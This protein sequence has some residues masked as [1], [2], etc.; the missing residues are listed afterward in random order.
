M[1]QKTALE[2]TVSREKSKNLE[3]AAGGTANFP[4]RDTILPAPRIYISQWRQG[5][6]ARRR[7][8]PHSSVGSVVL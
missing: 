4:R 2:G 6:A 1:G 3:T 7:L 8:L 5:R